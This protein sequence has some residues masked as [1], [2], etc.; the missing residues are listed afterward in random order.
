MTSNEPETTTTHTK[1]DDHQTQTNMQALHGHHHNF[2][3]ERHPDMPWLRKEAEIIHS[4]PQ[5]PTPPLQLTPP[6]QPPQPTPTLQPPTSPDTSDDSTATNSLAIRIQEIQDEW[7]ESNEKLLTFQNEAYKSIMATLDKEHKQKM[8]QIAENNNTLDTTTTKLND[9]EYNPTLFD[10]IVERH[11]NNI[12][13]THVVKDAK[14]WLV[15]L[16]DSNET[17][18]LQAGSKVVIYTIESEEI[19][20]NITNKKV[21]DEYNEWMKLLEQTRKITQR[22][23]AQIILL[24]KEYLELEDFDRA[25]ELLK[26]STTLSPTE[27]AFDI[28]SELKKVRSIAENQPDIEVVTRKTGIPDDGE[29]Y[30]EI[31]FPVEGYGRKTYVFEKVIENKCVPKQT[32]VEEVVH[33]CYLEEL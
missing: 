1:I 23:N 27:E 31:I 28:L 25:E 18:L 16:K 15:H 4:I 21:H 33:V 7:E 12:K 6:L 10:T 32:W 29:E 24:S 30:V 8:Q 14:A 2:V 13:M 3:A 11:L 9:L 5:L 20:Y 22:Q 26:K 17:I 19:I